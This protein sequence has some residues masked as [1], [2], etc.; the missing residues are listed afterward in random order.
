MRRLIALSALILFPIINVHGQSPQPCQPPAPAAVAQGSNI[1]SEQQ[2]VDLGEAI[3]EHLQRDFRVIADDD[4]TSYLGRIGQRLV[5]HLP[6]TRLRFQFFLVDIPEANA[7]VLPGGRVYVSR[8]LVAMTQNE[9]ELAGVIAHELGHIVAR[10]NAIGMTRLMREV[11]GVTEVKDRQDV[12]A[13]YNQLVENV[14]RKPKAFSKDDGHNEDQM[15]ADQTGLFALVAA[16]Y[17][18]QAFARFFDRLAETKGKTGN[19]FSD[20]FGTTRPEARRLREMI[21]LTAT[22]PA[23]CVEGRRSMPAEE[24][25]AWQAA[26]VNYT[27]LGARKRFTA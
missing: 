25:Q 15:T 5:K 26:V 11:L 6:Q 16:G 8:K 22:L 18:P 23:S 2:E 14:A 19:F 9:D 13:K 17:D 20:L 3:A 1:F 27:G 24:F 4:V 7:F 21:K 10:H 12:F